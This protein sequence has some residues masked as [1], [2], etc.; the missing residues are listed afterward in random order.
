VGLS[1]TQEELPCMH[2]VK[3]RSY[4]CMLLASYACLPA[5]HPLGGFNLKSDITNLQHK[6]SNSGSVTLLNNKAFSKLLPT[7]LLRY[8]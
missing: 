6:F 8:I 4:T 7:D 1:D 3:L 5:S 2:L